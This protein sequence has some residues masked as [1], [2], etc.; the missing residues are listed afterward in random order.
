MLHTSVDN[1]AMLENSRSGL[2][3]KLDRQFDEIVRGLSNKY[4]ELKTAI[5]S[6]YEEMIDQNKQANQQIK[7]ACK[8]ISTALQQLDRNDQHPASGKNGPPPAVFKHL[9]LQCLNTVQP[10]GTVQRRTSEI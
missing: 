3:A 10:A 8:T 5:G 7:S 6:Y 4:L 1:V 9:V 2:V